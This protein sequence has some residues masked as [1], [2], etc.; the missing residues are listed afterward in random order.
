MTE[1]E[2][3]SDLIQVDAEVV[4]K[5]LKI[6]PRELQQRMREGT[7][8]SRFEHGEGADAG[9]VRLTFY[10]DSR[11][12][13]ITADTSGA[14]LFCSAV[15]YGRPAKA[16]L[17]TPEHTEN[18]DIAPDT[19]KAASTRARLDALL[20]AALQDTFPA[21]DPIAIGFDPSD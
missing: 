12:A 19:A 11:R 1:I 9:R 20:D 10:S 7:V 6:A 17:P 18:T 3:G 14:I 13:R 16:E 8:T 5:A 15:D 2:I 21:S 4:A